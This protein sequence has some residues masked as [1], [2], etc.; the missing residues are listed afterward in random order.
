MSTKRYGP[1]PASGP[2]RLRY[3]AVRLADKLDE[4]E[5]VHPD[6][7]RTVRK[8]IAVLDERDRLKAA[9]ESVEWEGYLDYGIGGCAECKQ[10]QNKGH[11]GG[12]TIGAA[13]VQETP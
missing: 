9:L 12:C 8:L 5:G 1:I 3:K 2:E 10:T 6:D 7:G 11:S 13:L 4:I